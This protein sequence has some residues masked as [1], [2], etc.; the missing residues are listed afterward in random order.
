MGHNNFC[1][2]QDLVVPIVGFLGQLNQS[3]KASDTR[4]CSVW[5][6]EVHYYPNKQIIEWEKRTFKG[7]SEVWELAA[8]FRSEENTGGYC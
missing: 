2:Q 1:V 7:K 4:K 3:L 5:L 6:N 8:K